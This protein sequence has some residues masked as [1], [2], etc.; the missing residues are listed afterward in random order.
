MSDQL[1]FLKFVQGFFSHCSD[2][3]KNNKNSCNCNL[4][5]KQCN[6]NMFHDQSNHEKINPSFSPSPPSQTL[7]SSS[8][9][10]SNKN[11]QLNV[12][13]VVYDHENRT[14]DLSDVDTT[15]LTPVLAYLNVTL[16]SCNNIGPNVHELGFHLKAMID[17]GAG[18]TSMNKSFY[19][20]LIHNFNQDM[21]LLTKLPNVEIL[22]AVGGLTPITGMTTFRLFLSTEP[23]VFI[24]GTCMVIENL[25][26]DFIIGY[27]ILGS[28]FVHSISKNE[29]I[30]YDPQTSSNIHMPIERLTLPSLPCW[31]IKSRTVSPNEV[32]TIKSRFR[33]QLPQGTKFTVK[34]TKACDKIKILPHIFVSDGK[35]KRYDI[36][37]QN[38]ATNTI[39]L[40][41]KFPIFTVQVLDI[42]RPDKNIFLKPNRDTCRDF[43]PISKKGNISNTNKVSSTASNPF[44]FYPSETTPTLNLLNLSV[45][46]DTLN[47][48]KQEKDW[49]IRRLTKVS[50]NDPIACNENLSFVEKVDNLV[51]IANKKR[52]NSRQKE[53]KIVPTSNPIPC[54]YLSTKA[55]DLRTFLKD[56]KNLNDD[57]IQQEFT[58]AKENSYVQ[59]T[60]S[61]VIKDHSAITEI[62]LADDRPLS[63]D[64]FFN[65]F[66]IAHLNFEAQTLAKEIFLKNKQAFSLH[67]FDIGRTHLVEMGITTITQSPQIQKYIPIP[68]AVKEKTKEILDQMMKYDIIRECHEPSPYCSNI[69]VIK[70]KEKDSIRLLFDGRLLNYDT[71][72]EPMALITKP[73]ILAHF[74]EKKHLTS[75]DFSD[76][77]FHIPLKKESQPLTAFYAHTHGLRMCFNVAAQGLKN[78][79]TYLKLLLDKIFGC[80]TDNVMFYA[81]DCMI[82][83]DGTLEQ[84][85][86]IVDEVLQK[87]IHAGL[88]LRP[89]K[90]L[91]AKKHMEFLGLIFEKS[92]VSIPRLKL[93]A[94]RRLESPKTPKQARSL[95]CCLSFYRHFCPTFA[96]LGHELNELSYVHPTQFKW[97]PEHEQKLRTLIDIICTNAS[98]YLPNP[99]KTFYV[100]TDASGYCGAGRIYQ[101]DAQGNELVVAAV[102]RTFSKTERNYAIFKKEILALLY[103]LKSMDFFL[104][105]AKKLVILIDAKSI[106]YLRLAKESSGI[107]LR[108]SLELSKYNAEI[109]HIPGEENVV[110]DVLS[111]QDSRI[112]SLKEYDSCNQT[113]S[114]K[115]SMNL[116]RRLTLPERFEFTEK[117]VDLLLEGQSPKAINK[118]TT[119]KSKA[120]KGVKS[121]KNIPQTIGNKKVHLPSTTRNTRRPGTLLPTFTHKNGYIHNDTNTKASKNDSISIFPLKKHT[122]NF[123]TA[124]PNT[125]KKVI[126]DEKKNQIYLFVEHIT[127]TGNQSSE[128]LDIDFSHDIGNLNSDSDPDSETLRAEFLQN[129]GYLNNDSDSNSDLF[130]LTSPHNDSEILFDPESIIFDNTV[131]IFDQDNF[132]DFVGFREHEIPPRQE[133]IPN[134]PYLDTWLDNLNTQ[135]TQ[136]SNSDPNSDTD[137]DFIT[138][139]EHSIDSTSE[140]EEITNQH[141]HDYFD[142]IFGDSRGSNPR[143]ESSSPRGSTPRP[144]NSPQRDIDPSGQEP[145]GH[146]PQPQVREPEFLPQPRPQRD[147][148]RPQRLI[149]ED[150]PPP[151]PQTTSTQEQPISSQGSGTQP[152]NQPQR[153]T[154]PPQFRDTIGHTSQD[155][156]PDPTPRPQRERQRRRRLISEDSPTP[157]PRAT[158]PQGLPSQDRDPHGQNLPSQDENPQGPTHQIQNVDPNFLPHP[159][160]QRERRRRRRL[161]SE[162]SWSFENILFDE[163]VADPQVEQVSNPEPSTSRTHQRQQSPLSENSSNLANFSDHDFNTNTQ[164]EPEDV[165]DFDNRSPSDR[166]SNPQPSS[167]SETSHGSDETGDNQN[168]LY[169]DIKTA[170]NIITAGM[171][172]VEQFKLAQSTDELCAEHLNT[173][174]DTLHRNSNFRILDGMLFREKD[175]TL[176]PVLPKSLFETIIFTKHFTIYGA[177]S[178]MTRILREVNKHFFIPSK[179]FVERLKEITALCYLCQI[180]NTN[181]PAQQIKQLPLVNAPRLSWSIDMITDIPKS[182]KDNQQILLCVDDYTSY[183]VCV[184]VKSAQTSDIIEALKNGIFAQFGIPK[185]LR[186][187]QQTSFYNS[188]VFTD[189]LNK[190]G[191]TLTATAVASPFSNGR[192]ESQIKNVKFLLRKFL[193]QE[194]NK[195]RWDEHIPIITASHNKSVGIYGYSAEELM[196]GHQIPSNIDVLSILTPNLTKEEYADHIFLK[197]TRMRQTAQERKNKKNSENNTYKNQNKIL[198]QFKIGSLV[199]HKQMQA[200]TGSSSKYKPLFTGPYTILRINS[201]KCSALLEHLHHGNIIKA[202]FTNMQILN[203]DPEINKARDNFDENFLKMLEEKYTLEKYRAS[204]STF[205]RV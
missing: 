49:I 41:K 195:D 29:V 151:P 119:K 165:F 143:H 20:K 116:V 85:L 107:L 18:K 187:D 95:Y 177:H 192:A 112:S 92:Q 150:S 141:Y 30:F 152:Q 106:I 188:I 125:K 21:P 47:L 60:I 14:H 131:S 137:S 12:K 74:V 186:S 163:H 65:L 35:S 155:N 153:L 203:F 109:V 93:D 146:T 156:H 83:S 132:Q 173:D 28:D 128:N 39:S 148:R 9:Y 42:Q 27:D 175:A 86:R 71:I 172:T 80:M 36:S 102:S 6:S 63:T 166:D 154:P 5:N 64:E 139:S 97:T 8:K 140:Y 61:K 82:A 22:N 19:E 149:S 96:E 193:F 126:F 142:N 194:H 174:M 15:N 72:K 68:H 117:E 58:Y 4:S 189:F 185:I 157:P 170:T 197:A 130:S 13:K 44:L 40:N 167:G 26:E 120:T 135:N 11:I 158:H 45:H 33:T 181:C 184:P 100:Q 43:D 66:D 178:S 123:F 183:V 17:T 16:G 87:I 52:K 67:K 138:V 168:L 127:L 59:P 2:I 70:K 31:L 94:F 202:H 179:A 62:E 201:D 198:K 124:S 54:D 38:I 164:P 53:N 108:F 169:T 77:F 48:T 79:L 122:A 32:V 34:A 57:E 161:I 111:R 134:P 145:I 91:L 23:P 162:D 176:K 191:I 133:L 121:I 51:R 160:P 190:L 50:S 144:P 1:N 75:L 136:F 76:A 10:S 7:P 204:R 200:S 118:T 78:S 159:R 25:A 171:L 56:D 84:H 88:K 103:T 3:Q 182:T 24:D 55:L 205:P 81:D 69:L 46:L 110:S 104:R 199:I 114:E 147:H 90:L 101:K 113:L 196:F 73:E 89:Q 99:A 37:L 98:L 105:F 180:Y 129:I 115:D